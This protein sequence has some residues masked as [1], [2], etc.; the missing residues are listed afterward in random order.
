MRVE[1]HA[2]RVTLLACGGRLGMFLGWPLV[3]TLIA[4]TGSDTSFQPTSLLNFPLMVVLSI[5]VLAV[6][7]AGRGALARALGFS[8]PRVDFGILNRMFSYRVG[9]AVRSFS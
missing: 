9:I 2:V 8:V 7:E 6:R 3:A 5:V 1:A 4:I